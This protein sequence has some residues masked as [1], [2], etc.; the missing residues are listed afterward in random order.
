MG[1]SPVQLAM[2]E[3]TRTLT[4]DG[5]PHA[6]AGA[7]ALNEHGYMRATIDVDVLITVTDSTVS[8]NCISGADT[9][10]S[11]RQQRCPGRSKRREHR[12]LD[13]R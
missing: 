7:M 8:N 13:R 5:I 10:R 11:F 12:L 4:E 9:S 2:L 1:D 6:V 3:L